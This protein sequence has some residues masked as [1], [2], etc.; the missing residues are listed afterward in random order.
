MNAPPPSA[1][2]DGGGLMAIT[3]APKIITGRFGYA[4]SHTLA[5]YEATGGY[6]RPAQGADHV[7]RSGDR[8]R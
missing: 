7:A 8:P 2:A 1:D 3:D 6:A 5:R 4:D